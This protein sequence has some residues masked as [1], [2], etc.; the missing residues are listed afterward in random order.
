MTSRRLAQ[1]CALALFALTYWTVVSR[2]GVIG[3]E[4]VGMI[5]AVFFILTLLLFGGAFFL[6]RLGA[7]GQTVFWSTGRTD[8]VRPVIGMELAIVAAIIAAAAGL[9]LAGLDDPLSAEIT[10]LLTGT[11]I[12]AAC[13][14]S[15]VLTWPSRLHRPSWIRLVVIGGLAIGTAA[16]WA[17][18]GYLASTDKAALPTIP[19][20]VVSIGAVVVGATFEEV[21]FRVLLLTA[22]LDRTGSRFHAV[23]LSSVAFG[24]VH[25]PGM[26]IDPIL[27]SD[28]AGLQ[29]IAFDY[30]PMFLM[31]ILAGLLL[32]VLWLRTGSITLIALTHAILNLGKVFAYGLL[33]Y[34]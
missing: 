32:G 11:L 18:G 2:P 30:A 16:A 3:D 23:F 26:L 19:E 17:W 5:Y 22:I 8:Q 6:L 13:L 24:L 28:W 15:G 25:V 20:S 31:Q 34:G 21:I 12:P 27:H 1:L 4:F 10:Y 33:A 14:Q 29:K 9:Q 7:G